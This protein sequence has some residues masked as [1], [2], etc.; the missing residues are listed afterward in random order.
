MASQFLYIRAYGIAERLTSNECVSNL[1]ADEDLRLDVVIR[2]PRLVKQLALT[3][4]RDDVHKSSTSL[5]VC[6]VSDFAKQRWLILLVPVSREENFAY[7]LL[8]VVFIES[9]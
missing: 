1:Q 3:E 7:Q 5:R 9:T 8:E 2:G 6:D 4:E